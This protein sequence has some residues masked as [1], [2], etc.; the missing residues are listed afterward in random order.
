MPRRGITQPGGG[1]AAAWYNST[2][3]FASSHLTI[4]SYSSLPQKSGNISKYLL[5]TNLDILILQN[6]LSHSTKTLQW[7]HSWS[8]WPIQEG[9]HQ[10][11]SRRKQPSCPTPQQSALWSLSN[12][13]AAPGP[14]HQAIQPSLATVGQ[15]EEEKQ[16]KLLSPMLA[17]HCT[18]AH[19]ASSHPAKKQQDSRQ[20]AVF[21][22]PFTKAAKS[23]YTTKKPAE[24]HMPLVLQINLAS[25]VT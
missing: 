23:T 20:V 10:T 22:L 1:P 17:H 25:Q 14:V 5:L 2:K 13:S 11:Q 21:L 4:L 12:S 8:T 16:E 3:H 19:S 9:Y 18:A 6:F 24:F 7:N 15:W